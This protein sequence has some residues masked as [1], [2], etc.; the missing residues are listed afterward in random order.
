MHTIYTSQNIEQKEHQPEEKLRTK[1]KT[2]ILICRLHFMICMSS[3]ELM[4]FQRLIYVRCSA[5][6]YGFPG[7]IFQTCP[8]WPI[9]LWQVKRV[10]ACQNERVEC[11]N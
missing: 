8:C 9:C 11:L 4:W 10:C 2:T 1:Q 3:A 6:R 5:S 7:Y